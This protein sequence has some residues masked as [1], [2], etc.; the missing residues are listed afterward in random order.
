MLPMHWGSAG[1]RSIGAL[2]NMASDG[3][4]NSAVR[5]KRLP[6]GA[7]R[8]R[9][10]FERRLR[11]WL[12]LLGL[13]PLVLCWVLLWQHSTGILVQC[14]LLLIFAAGWALAVS[15]LTEQITRPLQTLSNVV[16]A[17][18]EDD[19]SF[20]ARGGRRDDS[21][22]DLA[23]EINTL[24]SMLQNQRAGSL[25][26]MALVERVMSSMQSPVLAFDPEGRLKL[27]NTA[28]ERAF[29]LSVSTAL[30]RPAEMLKLMHLLEA[31]DDALLSLDGAQGAARWV[32]KR[33]SFRLR[34]VPHAL[35]VLS[36]VSAALHE[37][38]RTAWRRLIRVLGHEINNSLTPI[39]S[40]AGSLRGRFAS[41]LPPSADHGDSSDFEGGLEV[42][43]N[44]AESLNRFLQA[45][46]Q[47]MGL[48]APKLAPVSLAML[49]ERVARLETRID[50]AIVNTSDVTLTADAD[51]VQQAL[52]NLARNAV[53]A[54]LN[55]DRVT[56]KEP[57]V[58]I[59]WE[60]A[61]RE[62]II[63]ILD[64][65]AGLMNAE[66]LFVPFYTTKPSGTGIGLVLAQQI[67]QA[68]KGSVR[69]ANRSDG[70][71]GCRAEL[72]LPILNMESEYPKKVSIL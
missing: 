32:V 67:A 5:R 41:L 2:R 31:D 10:S 64:N 72:R 62:I 46:R 34:G 51:Q 33:S 29:G 15:F 35:L 1:E 17:L 48:P 39:K 44:R 14:L 58:E 50:I 25:E 60:N 28:G 40:I 26:A 43:E 3:R 49:V 54:A 59:A 42:I 69:L 18:R 20:R 38:E 63:S 11:I 7:S 4:P 70:Q 47:L 52:I 23:L 24:A 6:L 55:V 66:N 36:D 16:A 68:H 8:H 12:Y 71:T 22:G 61:G 9:F 37:E 30:N 57:K 56:H 19:Y 53:E 27:L 45:Y 21:L 13:P 65:G